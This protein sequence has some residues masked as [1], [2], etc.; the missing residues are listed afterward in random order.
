MS[1]AAFDMCIDKNHRQNR[2]GMRL[3]ALHFCWNF[4][5][6]IRFYCSLCDVS[7]ERLYMPKHQHATHLDLQLQEA[8]PSDFVLIEARPTWK[9]ASTRC[10]T[11]EAKV[12]SMHKM[13]MQLYIVS[14]RLQMPGGLCVYTH[15]S[16]TGE[17][18]LTIPQPTQIGGAEEQTDHLFEYTQRSAQRGPLCCR[19]PMW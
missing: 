19:L 17:R 3:L 10:T 15:H 8:K 5:T 18:I 2:H 16:P 4:L 12:S 7:H 14:R 1:Q 13:S 11:L 9:P 6:H